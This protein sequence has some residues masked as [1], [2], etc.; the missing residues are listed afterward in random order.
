MARGFDSKD[1][2]YQQS[3]AQR[4][5]STKPALTPAEREEQQR[6]RGLEL[7][8]SKARAELLRATNPVHRRMLESAIHDLEKAIS[9]MEAL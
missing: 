1:V 8:L 3:E 5:P 9:G 4:S 2:E 7:A 6:V